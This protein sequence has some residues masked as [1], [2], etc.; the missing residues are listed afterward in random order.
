[1]RVYLS[2]QYLQDLCA[3][4]IKAKDQAVPSDRDYLSH[5]PS[6]YVWLSGGETVSSFLDQYPKVSRKGEP[7]P[8]ILRNRH[9]A[10]LAMAHVLDQEAAI[11]HDDLWNEA[12]TDLKDDWDYEDFFYEN[13]TPRPESD[14]DGVCDED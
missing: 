9:L 4:M 10:V 3:K 11:C 1:M 12:D 8:E 13:G 2:E 5:M 7:T 6:L 14:I